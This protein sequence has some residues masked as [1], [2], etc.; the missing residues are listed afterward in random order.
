MIVFTT[1]RYVPVSVS[2]RFGLNGI[3]VQKLLNGGYGI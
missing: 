1:T 2:P 3:D